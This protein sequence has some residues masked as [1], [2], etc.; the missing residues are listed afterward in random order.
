MAT[1]SKKK[2][3]RAKAG[4]TTARV[5][6][7]RSTALSMLL[8]GKS[9]PEIGDALGVT[10]ERAWQVATEAIDMLIAET[11]DKAEGWRA[12]LTREHLENLRYGRDLMSTTGSPEA[13][14]ATLDAKEL[15]HN[16][17]CKALDK[18]EK[19][20][21]AAVL[22]PMVTKTDITTNG[23]EIAGVP[24][25]PAKDLSVLSDTELEAILAVRKK[26][27]GTPDEE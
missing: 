25:V 1:K 24:M 7:M 27:E 8:E 9:C 26:L 20:W 18:L 14:E 4:A 16:I 5:E 3:P 17:V 2:T 11:L 19:L 22:V 23:K 6:T 10:R 15:G 21:G 13:A 12:I